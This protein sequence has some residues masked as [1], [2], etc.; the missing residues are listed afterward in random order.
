MNGSTQDGHFAL[1]VSQVGGQRSNSALVKP[2][3]SNGFFQ[4][5]FRGANSLAGVAKAVTMLLHDCQN[6]ASFG[7]R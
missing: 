3:A 4:R 6:L 7:F 2:L 5:L 1:E